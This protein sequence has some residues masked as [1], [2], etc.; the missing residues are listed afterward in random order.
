MRTIQRIALAVALFSG[1]AIADDTPADDHTKVVFIAGNPSHAPGDHEHR[2]GSM[3]L[4]NSLNKTM[5]EIETEVT[6]YGWPD[7]E[8]F[9][10]GADAVV[11]YCDGGGGHVVNK[12]MDFMQGLMDKGIGLV[13]I[14]YAVEVPPGEIGDQF[15]TWLGGYFETH[16]SVNPHW[17]ADF[18]E[19]PAHPIARGIDPFAINDEWYY[20]MRFPEAMAGVTPILT[21]MPGEDTLTRDDGPHSGNPHVREAVK[22]GE[23]QHVAW[24]YERPDGGRSF[25]FTGGHFH[26]NWKDDNHRDTVLNAIVWAAGVEVP[27]AGVNSPTPTDDEMKV[28]LDHKK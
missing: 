13:C 23:A 3:L 28:N 21:A 10:D 25:G 7:D 24:A 19:L 11:I 9:F 18:K 20:H 27:E 1:T 8:S 15:L 2:A 5:P 16:W 6:W 22:K 14:H 17:D 12:H 4:A 26:R